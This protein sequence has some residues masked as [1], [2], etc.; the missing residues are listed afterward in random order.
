MTVEVLN[1]VASI[2]TLLV[3]SATAI[4][5]IVQLRHMRGNN[6]IV[7]LTECREVLE[8]EEFTRALRFVVREL[9]ERLKDPNTRAALMSQPLP[10]DLRSVTV[11]GNFFESMG[12]FVK[13]D[14]IDEDIA[15]DLWS[16]IVARAWEHLVP[17]LGVMRRTAGTGLWDNFEYL[18]A[19]AEAFVASHPS[20][21]Y[22]AEKPRLN[23]EDRWATEDKA[24]GI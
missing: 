20:G 24:L 12:S 6:Q 4:A 16:G 22:P 19:I 13:H 7:A 8:S 17:A 11:V 21:T 1:A 14:I 23:V 3:I 18:A 5:A 9:H 15:M 2:G 10:E